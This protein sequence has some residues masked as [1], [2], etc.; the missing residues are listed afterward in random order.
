MCSVVYVARN[1]STVRV[2]SH[3]SPIVLNVATK[4]KPESQPSNKP[5]L[6]LIDT[7]SVHE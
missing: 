7:L 6:F 4:S 3:K 5:Q 2:H 1:M